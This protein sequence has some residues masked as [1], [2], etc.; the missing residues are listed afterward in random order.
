MAFW[1]HFTFWASALMVFSMSQ[2]VAQA[3]YAWADALVAAESRYGTGE[4]DR[5]VLMCACHAAQSKFEL[6][7][8]L[9]CDDYWNYHLE[10]KYSE[11]VFL[12]LAPYGI[13]KEDGA[14][15]YI[16]LMDTCAED[17]NG[18]FY[19]TIMSE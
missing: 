2:H 10:K 19:K 3:Q 15:K 12:V 4:Q 16:K 13:Q 7:E 9:P 11:N 1:T 6:E 18:N 14:D 5:A 8:S 17:E